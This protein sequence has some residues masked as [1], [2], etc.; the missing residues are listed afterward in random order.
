MYHR[1]LP[2]EDARALLE[3]PGMMVTPE[4]F[5][6]HIN[7]LR[8]YFDIIKLADWIRLKQQGKPLPARACAITFDDGWADNYEFAFPILKQLNVPASIFLVADMIGTD[9]AFWPER[10]AR[11]ITTVSQRYPQYW[12]HPELEWLQQDPAH[13]RFSATPPTQEQ[14]SELI[15]NAKHHTDQEIHQRLDHIDDVLQLEYEP[16]APALLDWA[17]LTE[18][19]ESGLIDAGSH[20]CRHVRLNQHTPKDLLSNEIVNSKTVIEKRTGRTIDTFCYPNGD[21]CDAALALVKQHYDCA[22]TTRSGWNTAATDNHL[23]Q[24]IGVHQDISADRTAFLSRLSG[25]M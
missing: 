16:H 20:T 3:E 19:L 6:L 14:L 1:I 2:S 5:K 9:E 21:L 13:Y 24:R 22:V 12:S 23:L 8:Q 4:T 11:L 7:L 18:M 17:Q 15:A 25:W 10:L